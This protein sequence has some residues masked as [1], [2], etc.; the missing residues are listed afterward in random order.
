MRWSVEVARTSRYR[1]QID[2]MHARYVGTG[3]IHELTHDGVA[4]ASVV[5]DQA[6]VARML[7]RTVGRGRYQP[8]PVRV[9]TVFFD[10]PR[11]LYRFEALD[12]VVHGVV[13]QLLTEL[14]EPLLSPSVYSYRP[15]ASP[16]GA[17]GHFAA[18]V[19]AH[20]AAV[21]DPKQRGLYVLRGDVRKYI[22]TMPLDA[23][24][25]LWPELRALTGLD[26]DD[27]HWRLVEQIVR[28]E[29]YDSDERFLFC[30]RAGLPM[31]S[32]AA[33]S[34]LNLYLRP[35]DRALDALG[36]FY[37]RFGDDL[38]F[39][40][41]DPDRVRAAA[42]AVDEGLAARGLSINE[43][44]RRTLFFNGAARPSAAWP[45]AIGAA[46]V[47]FLGASVRFDGST[48]LPRDKWREL[49]LELRRRLARCRAL[50]V[51]APLEV[52]G[53][54]LCAVVNETLDPR[55][56]LAHRHATLLHTL[57]SDRHQLAELDYRAA[58]LVAE[59]LT[60]E[61]SVRALRRVPWRR[62]RNDFGLASQVA[63]RNGA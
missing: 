16:A 29:V 56:A 58:R 43:K 37:A 27:P 9:K 15:R 1:K 39:A 62:M 10:K 8:S 13:G 2:L 26:G 25:P 31:G 34:L 50:L 57:V 55:S 28:P 53:P 17:L 24:S 22:E 7:A 20:R 51:D 23:R 19:R 48:A 32:P 5:Q 41:A 61:P 60:G 4:F 47:R 3:R 52:R 49:L 42:R 11:D 30:Q 6:A 54:A 40:H 18:F 59:M 12:F 33:T 14:L 46:E 63:L 45:E 36:G 44:K 21:A 35:I 38:L